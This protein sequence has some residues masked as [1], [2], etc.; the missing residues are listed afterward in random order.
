MKRFL[1]ISIALLSY[2]SAL[3]QSSISLLENSPFLPP[4]KANQAGG[5]AG[6]TGPSSLTHLQLRGITS[7]DGE[8]IF[9]IY[10]T[11]SRQS[12]WIKQGE[13]E[14]GLT[15]KSYDPE[16]N[17]VVIHSESENLS[18]QLQLNNY[19]APVPVKA[20]TTPRTLPSS[21]QPRTTTT[22]R[23]LPRTPETIQRPSR[24]NL[25][26]LRARR[27]ALADQLRRQ[28]Q[29]ASKPPNNSQGSA[30]KPENAPKR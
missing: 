6:E 16:D 27:Q 29:P 15:I 28:Q 10:N 14:E 1:F 21:T 20:S 17:E 3:A 26:T 24:R 7:I 23:N 12:K 5:N 2:I 11:Q 22:S 9:S 30:S 4:A 13:E 18:R 25:E 19:S 8:Y